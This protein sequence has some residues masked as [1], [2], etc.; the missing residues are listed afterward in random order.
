MSSLKSCLILATSATLSLRPIALHAECIAMDA[1][2]IKTQNFS[3]RLQLRRNLSEK[4]FKLGKS[5]IAN[6]YSLNSHT[7]K[8]DHQIACE[9][10]RI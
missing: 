1:Y 9:N 5:P 2:K 10:S 8:P 7:L 3:E 4:F 6:K